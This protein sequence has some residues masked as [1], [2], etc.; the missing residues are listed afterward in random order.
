MFF[1]L[2][3]ILSA[4][5]RMNLIG[6]MEGAKLQVQMS[7]MAESILKSK[8]N[9]SVDDAYQSAPYLDLVQARHDQLYTRI[10]NS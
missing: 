5:T 4:A 6:P 7:G 8:K 10:F 3:D 1:T 9:R 2:R